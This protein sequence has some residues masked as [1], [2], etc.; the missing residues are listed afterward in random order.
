MDDQKGAATAEAET[1]TAAATE[2]EAG[3]AEG[4]EGKPET[5]A[6]TAPAKKSWAERRLGEE[7]AR[8]RAL[9]AE[10]VRLRT[11]KAP[12]TA[13]DAARDA[14]EEARQAEISRQAEV[15]AEQKAQQREFDSVCNQIYDTGNERYPD[16]DEAM[17]EFG[18]VSGGINPAI[19]EAAVASDD[20]AAALYFMGKDPD[21]AERILKLSPAR[22]GVAMAKLVQAGKK[23]PKKASNAPTPPNPVG[24]GGTTVPEGLGE[25]VP[26]ATWVNRFNKQLAEKR[27]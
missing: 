21:E 19:V 23:P 3:K 15:L 11:D 2:A 22:A 26:M 16:W 4:A 12:P 1:T 8:R 24:G 18:K 5:V 17:A 27:R 10:V 20:P 14:A 25:N 6:A 7:T 13:V 9:E